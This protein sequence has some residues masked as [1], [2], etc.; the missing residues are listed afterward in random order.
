MKKL[1]LTLLIPSMTFAESAKLEEAFNL[2]NQLTITSAQAEMV[3]QIKADLREAHKLSEKA[4]QDLL[5]CL[6]REGAKKD[7]EKKSE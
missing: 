6:D 7:A 1:L 2:V 3:S 4:Q 5:A